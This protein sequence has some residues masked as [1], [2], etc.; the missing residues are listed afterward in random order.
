MET[1]KRRNLRIKFG[2]RNCRTEGFIAI[3]RPDVA[4]HGAPVLPTG[5]LREPFAV[6]I[7]RRNA[8]ALN[9]LHHCEAESIGFNSTVTLVVEI[10]LRE[11]VGVA[12]QV[13]RS[14]PSEISPLS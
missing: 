3:I 14:A 13:S 9:V 12:M 5:D 1:A 4:Q 6:F 7:I 8:D 10:E 2:E 11:H